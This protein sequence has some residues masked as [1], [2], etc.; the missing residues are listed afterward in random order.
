[1]HIDISKQLAQDPWFK[2]VDFLQQNWAVIIQ[3]KT[4]VLI[5]FY[6][7]T[8]GIFDEIPFGTATEAKQALQRNGFSKFCDDKQAKE[9]ISLPQGEFR[10]RPHPNGRIYS[11]GRYWI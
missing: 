5:V 9:F 3:R 7:D 11:S 4:D 10:E 1:M 8:C 2:V 6:G